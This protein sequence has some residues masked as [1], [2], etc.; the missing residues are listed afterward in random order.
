LIN[1]KI[2]NKFFYREKVDDKKIVKD[3]EK[4]EKDIEEEGEIMAIANPED[5]AAGDEEEVLEEKIYDL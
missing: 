1:K 4:E 3:E 5:E 2:A